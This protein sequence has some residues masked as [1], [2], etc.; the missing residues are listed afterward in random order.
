MSVS[1]A[2][3]RRPWGLY[4][5]IDEGPG[6]KV[7]R[8]EVLP[9]RR[10]SYQRHAHRAEHWMVVRGTA[11][12]TLDG[13]ELIVDVGGTVD[14]PVGAAHRI[15]PVGEGVL[16]FIEIQRGSY[17]GEDD[18]ARLQDDYGRATSSAWATVALEGRGDGGVRAERHR[19]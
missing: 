10:L 5:V 2:S 16:V 8:I 12:V 11:R 9:G 1:P 4:T 17:L 14:V 3:E 13:C 7:K 6:Y 15:E 18:I 19:A